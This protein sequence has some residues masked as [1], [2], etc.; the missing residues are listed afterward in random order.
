MRHRAFVPG[1]LALVVALFLQW[2]EHPANQLPAPFQ[3]IE[4]DEAAVAS[5]RQV[6]SRKQRKDYTGEAQARLRRRAAEIGE[7]ASR[8]LLQ[9][10]MEA[11]VMPPAEPGAVVVLTWSDSWSSA[12]GDA[13]WE[14]EGDLIGEL[15]TDRTARVLAWAVADR[16]LAW[17]LRR[18]LV[19]AL[20]RPRFAFAADALARVACDRREKPE[21]RR[22]VLL[23]FHRLGCATPRPIKDLLYQSYAG[24]DVLAAATLAMCGEPCAPSLLI[25]GLA[26]GP[27]R[28]AETWNLCAHAAYRV[29]RRPL[30]LPAALETTTITRTSGPDGWAERR[31]GTV[32]SSLGGHDAEALVRALEEWR[33]AHDSAFERERREYLASDGRRREMARR[34]LEEIAG[35]GDDLDLA[36]ASLWLTSPSE[37]ETGIALER[38]HRLCLLCE[39]RLAG[40]R[41]VETRIRVLNELLSCMGRRAHDDASHLP[42]LLSEDDGNCLARSTLYLSVGQRL[43]LPLHAYVLPGHVFVAWEEDGERRNIETTDRGNSRPDEGTAMSP[44][45]VLG[46]HLSNRAWARYDAEAFAE[47]IRLADEALMLDPAD[48]AAYLA[49]ANATWELDL[50]ADPRPDYDRALEIV[51]D[52]ASWWIESAEMACKLGFADDALRRAQKGSTIA[53]SPDASA[54]LIRAHLAS[55]NAARAR[56]LAEEAGKRWPDA[57]GALAFARF[58]LSLDRE[59]TAPLE[60]DDIPVFWKARALLV[61]ASPNRALERLEGERNVI[62]HGIDARTHDGG[63]IHIPPR[64]GEPREFHLLE[65]RALAQ[66]GRLDE[67]REVLRAAEEAG[68]PNRETLEVRRLLAAK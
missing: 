57:R 18:A 29:L 5:L 16:N 37:E 28:N 20:S 3:G 33:V 9:I 32:R 15:C 42:L 21:M 51:P 41:S 62:L 68:L 66:L 44:R 46:R 64:K 31:E 48:E 13:N 30:E 24:I 50:D 36:A 12:D 17:G 38:L 8:A 65:A 39:R 61:R 34:T 2:R 40:A 59:G 19:V 67:A 14:P 49:R 63:T 58:E 23:R 60:R 45:A 4:R 6:W 35:A 27:D 1:L 7:P 54:A 56:E 52:Q 53:P 43:G 11:Y 25:E 10:L 47:A 26:A 55:G 22:A